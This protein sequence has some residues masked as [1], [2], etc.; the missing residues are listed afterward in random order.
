MSSKPTVTATLA[1][2]ETDLT[3]AFDR[4]GQAADQMDAQVSSASRGMEAA[5]DRTQRVTEAFDTADTRAMGFR[6]T[7]T[8]LQDGFQGLAVAVNVA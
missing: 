8:G 3:R 5:G 1:G 6:D 4:V 2:D 7:L